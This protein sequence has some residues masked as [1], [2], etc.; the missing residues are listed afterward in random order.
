[1]TEH[2][3]EKCARCG[4]LGHD[5]R[6]LWMACFYEMR[7]LGMPFEMIGL[8]GAIV[9]RVTGQKHS[10]W[11]SCDEYTN[12]YPDSDKSREDLRTFH[13]MRVCKGCRGEWMTAIQSWYRATPSSTCEWN[14]DASHAS[15]PISKLL[16]RAEELRTELLA[17]Q[18]EVADTCRELRHEHAR[19]EMGE[20]K[21]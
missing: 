9:E 20:A 11:G 1:M 19:R 7:E 21:P 6:T 3:A 15:E 10:S 5:R 2:E 4:T 17:V 13:T 16:A 18:Q 14:N 12:T 8:R